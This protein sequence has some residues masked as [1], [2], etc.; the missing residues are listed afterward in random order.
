M[1]NIG[2]L[3]CHVYTAKH[4]IEAITQEIFDVVSLDHDLSW[5][6]NM[7]LPKQG[8]GSGYDVAL[9]IAE[10]EEDKRPKAVVLHSW[11]PPG[12]QR[13]KQALEGK[14]E[15]LLVIPFSFEF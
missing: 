1:T 8:G 13:M 11:N 9:F 15:K 5:E 14:V 6:D 4:A 12:V 7:K 3:V 2:I 10:M